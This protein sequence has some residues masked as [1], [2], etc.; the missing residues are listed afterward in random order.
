MGR[1]LLKREYDDHEAYRDITLIIESD[2]DEHIS[3]LHRNLKSFARALGYAEQ[4]VEEY[5][6]EDY[7]ND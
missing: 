4:T 6:G 3:E 2:D 1:L 7:W 5:F